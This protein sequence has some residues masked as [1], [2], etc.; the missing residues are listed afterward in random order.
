MDCYNFYT[1]VV[2]IV[3]CIPVMFSIY[4]ITDIRK[5]IIKRERNFMY[6]KNDIMENET[7]REYLISEDYKNKLNNLIYSLSFVIG[8]ICFIITI[9]A[10]M[11]FM[12]KDIEFNKPISVV[13]IDTVPSV[14]QPAASAPI[15][16][17]HHSAMFGATGLQWIT[18]NVASQLPQPIASWFFNLFGSHKVAPNL[19]NPHQGDDEHVGG[20]LLIENPFIYKYKWF[21]LLSIF[22]FVFLPLS[23]ISINTVNEYIR[24]KNPS[25]TE[26][27]E[28]YNDLQ[29]YLK[30]EL[31]NKNIKDFD[32]GFLKQYVRRTN[33]RVTDISSS[34]L[35][36]NENIIKF[37]GQMRP[38]LNYFIKK[39]KESVQDYDLNFVKKTDKRLPDLNNNIKKPDF[40]FIES[41]MWILLIF[42]FYNIY[43]SV[44]ENI[45]KSLQKIVIVIVILV[46][47]CL[48][49]LYYLIIAKDRL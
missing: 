34:F 40:S 16:T 17:N 1:I 26:Y 9:S 21:I 2:I 7:L 4:Y 42:F 8:I 39:D 43:D 27:A 13:P 46:L 37:L 10:I 47:I 33:Q 44:Y 22:T 11:F 36:K 12:N 14:A 49:F 38:S 31:R 41:V 19:G 15:N 24:G 30:I 29:K 32:D 20:G 48:M 5:D 23:V 18:T 3:I 25:L 28:K 6:C 45:D 35:E